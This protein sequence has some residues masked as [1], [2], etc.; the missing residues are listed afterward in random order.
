MLARCLALIRVLVAGCV[1]VAITGNFDVRAA[2]DSAV[3]ADLAQFE[4]V[5]SF[6]T[7]K[8]NGQ[9]QRGAGHENDRLIFQKDGRFTVVQRPGITH[10][11]YKV[12][13]GHTPKQYDVRIETGRL[14]GINVPAIY[15]I[16]GDTLTICMP[17]AGNERPTVLESKPGD[18]CL[19][20][21]FKRQHEGVKDVLIAAGRRELTGT[22][23][24]VTYALHG[25]KASDDDIKKIQLVFD[26]EG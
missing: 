8:V 12:D 3:K 25:K 24:A 21:V 26:G 14:K 1:A 6:S 18:A 13:P 10:G 4:G 16:A 7:V 17:L 23:Q 2:D 22:W 15:E 11:T 20:E 9:P 19:F 5:W